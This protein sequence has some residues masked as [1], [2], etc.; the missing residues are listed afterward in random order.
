VNGRSTVT[1]VDDEPG[2]ADLFA[3][4]LEGTYE[5]RTAYGGDRH[6]TSWTTASTRYSSIG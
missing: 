4:W 2:L 1:V 5:V 6:S 3:A